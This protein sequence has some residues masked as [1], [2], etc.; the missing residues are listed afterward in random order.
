MKL[1]DPIKS[2]PLPGNIARTMGLILL[3]LGGVLIM[4]SL[5]ISIKRK[6]AGPLIYSV[7]GVTL[8]GLGVAIDR[9]RGKIQ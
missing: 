5:A 8:I 1:T 7:V 6:V 9:D 3:T 4:L 2:K